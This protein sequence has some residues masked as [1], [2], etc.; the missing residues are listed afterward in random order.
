[1]V[2]TYEVCALLSL[3]QPGIARAPRRRWD[4]T[5]PLADLRLEDA[6]VEAVLARGPAAATL[7]RTLAIHLEFALAADGLG[8]ADA[9]LAMTVDYLQT[10]QQFGRPL[11]MFQALKHR[12]ADL[13]ARLAAAE[14][15]FWRLSEGRGGSG[16]DELTE[17]G[18]LKS[19]VG[20]VYSDVGEEAIQLHGGIA[21][22]A[23]HPCHLFVKRALANTALGGEADHWEA[24]AGREAI[25]RLART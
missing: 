23:E 7:A 14:A 21:M 12:C 3:D 18:A 25:G 6:R 16:L 13:K 8:G 22:T 15:L 1:L 19:H 17:A 20:A 24:A 4:E 10:R 9:L 2:S 5:R 11:A